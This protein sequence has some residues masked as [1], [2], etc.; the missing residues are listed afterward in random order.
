MSFT[1]ST[2]SLHSPPCPFSNLLGAVLGTLDLP[3]VKCSGNS[4]NFSSRAHSSSPW[5][6]LCA[7]EP[8]LQ[9]FVICDNFDIVQPCLSIETFWR[10]RAVNSFL[11]FSCSKRFPARTAP[12]KRRGSNSEPDGFL[13]MNTKGHPERY[14]RSCCVLP[15]GPIV[16]ILCDPTASGSQILHSAFSGQEVK[17]RPRRGAVSA[18]KQIGINVGSRALFW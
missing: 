2:N 13:N 6:F 5:N 17:W 9:G 16:G 8:F 11:V 4:G 3:G 14:F 1:T 15:K 12:M 10:P 18:L 7:N